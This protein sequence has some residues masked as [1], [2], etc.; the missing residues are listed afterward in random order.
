MSTFGPMSSHGDLRRLV[1]LALPGVVLGVA[2]AT[3]PHSLSYS[4]S[5]HW[6]QMH[7][8]GMFVFPLVGVALM[9]LVWGRRDPLA[10]VLYAG[11]FVYAV[12][13]TALDVISGIT[14]G[15]ITYRLGP[16]EPRPDEVRWVFEIGGRIGDVGEWGLLVA[17][18]AASVDLARRVGWPALV[19]AVPLLLGT[20]W[21]LEDHIFPPYGA[22]GA[23]L[24][25]IGTAGLAWAQ[26]RARVEVQRRAGSPA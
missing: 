10:L 21:V 4:T 5:E 15:W 25:G 3:H 19:G 14:A 1:L 12:C 9:S 24:V 20:W 6:W 26:A 8:A 22:L 23:A 2:G 17:A 7:V 11:A 16:G 13:Y 18:V